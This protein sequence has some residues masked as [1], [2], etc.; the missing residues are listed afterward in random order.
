MLDSSFQGVNR[1]FVFGF[2]DIYNNF[3]VE[4]ND[5]RKYFLPRVEIKDYNVLIDGRY[6]YNQNISD[7]LRNYDEVRNIM[8]GKGEDNT[9]GSLLDYAYYKDHYKLITCDLSK[10][11]ILASDPKAIQQQ[12][13]FIFRLDNTNNNTAQF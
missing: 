4:R 8:T 9:T 12:I 5:H 11:K 1:L 6:F 3:R 7:E 2:N 10:Q 13:E